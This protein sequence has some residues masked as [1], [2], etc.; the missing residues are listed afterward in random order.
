MLLDRCL[1]C[2]SVTLL[3]CGQTVGWVMVKLGMQVSLGPGHTV[4]HGQH[5]CPDRSTERGTA[6]PYFRNLRAHVLPAYV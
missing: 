4:L 2:L 5:V 6:A 3:Y 1:A